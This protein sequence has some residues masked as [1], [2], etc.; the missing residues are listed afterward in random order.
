MELKEISV[1]PEY[2]DAYWAAGDEAYQL[3]EPLGEKRTAQL[4]AN[5][6]HNLLLHRRLFL[7]D[8]S[9]LVSPSMF[10]LLRDEQYGPG[11]QKLFRDGLIVTTMRASA[12]NYAEVAEI[13]IEKRHFVAEMEKERIR[14]SA[15]LLDTLN[16]QIIRTDTRDKMRTIGHR[17]LLKPEYWMSLGLPEKIAIKM[18]RSVRRKIAARRLETVRQTEFWEYAHDRLVRPDQ[19]AMAQQVRAYMTIASLGTMAKGIGLPPIFPAA[20]GGSVDRLYGTR[21]PWRHHPA[22]GR[23]ELLEPFEEKSPRRLEEER[24]I[25]AIAALLTADQISEVRTRKEHQKFLKDI[26]KYSKDESDSAAFQ[27]D[28][29]M[30]E[31]RDSLEVSAGEFLTEWEHQ[32]VS[33]IWET[34]RGQL[35]RLPVPGA[36]GTVAARVNEMSHAIPDSAHLLGYGSGV[37][38]GAALTLFAWKKVKGTKNQREKFREATSEALEDPSVIPELRSE[39]R[40]QMSLFGSI[41]YRF[42]AE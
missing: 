9:I 36:V 8:T 34:P 27:I 21:T 41:P 24:S 40:I 14:E 37:T 17:Y 20:Y 30:Q 32:G 5:I 42:H 3:L 35:A 12:N 13:V 4:R 19:A 33:W 16:P 6:N 28:R 29:T 25:H 26:E 39:G 7:A 23:I 38:V 10:T 2:P 22:D 31:F 11:Y 18:T 15:S 1:A